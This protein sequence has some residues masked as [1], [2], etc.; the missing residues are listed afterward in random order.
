[1]PESNKE[2]IKADI[3]DTK[4]EKPTPFVE[5]DVNAVDNDISGAKS[6]DN[7]M[8]GKEIKTDSAGEGKTGSVVAAKTNSV[9]ADKT[10]NMEVEEEGKSDADETEDFRLVLED[11]VAESTDKTNGKATPPKTEKPPPTLLS[12]TPRRVQLIT[13]SSPKRTKAE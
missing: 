4:E 3:K 5:L 9:A 2:Q 13:L 6:K 11:T 7:D 1:M 10:G 12:R 8:N